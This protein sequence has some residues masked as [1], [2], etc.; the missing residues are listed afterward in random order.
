[1]GR[2]EKMKG[3][4]SGVEMKPKKPSV[5]ARK[6]TGKVRENRV[7]NTCGK[8]REKGKNDGGKSVAEGEQGGKKRGKDPEKPRDPKKGGGPEPGPWGENNCR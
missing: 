6:I 1:V 2:G 4:N 8:K 5:G 7:K 3:A